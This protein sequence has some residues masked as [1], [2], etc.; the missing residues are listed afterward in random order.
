MKI[1]NRNFRNLAG[2]GTKNGRNRFTVRTATSNEV[3]VSIT[4]PG[5]KKATTLEIMYPAARSNVGSR[6]AGRLV[7]NG[8]QARELYETLR[9]VYEN[10]VINNG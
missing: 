5:S 7:L 2:I 6:R 4:Q 9:A 1:A 3:G 10:G 8:R